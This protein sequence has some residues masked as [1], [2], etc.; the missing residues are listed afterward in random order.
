VAAPE[1]EDPRKALAR[2]GLAPK[3]SFSQNFLVARSVVEAIAEAAVPASGAH[4]VELG[5]GLGTLTGALL[6]R[7]ARVTAVERDR[8][9]IA[10]LKS[11]L[12]DQP[13]VV[14]E[15]DAADI[16]LGALAVDGPF[17]LAGNLPYA[18][19]GAILTNLGR[20]RRALTQAVLMI[21]KEVRDRLLASPGTK[22]WGMSSVFVQAAFDVRPV[23]RVPAGAFHP[24]PK[25]ESAV[26]R[27]VPRAVA[28]AEET[29]SFVRVV[30]AGFGTR[31]KTL[32]NALG[33]EFERD[34]V[35]AALGACGIDGDR[36]AETLT[37]EELAALARAME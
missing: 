29:P 22:T 17:A 1:W 23:L 19:T 18:A 6:R 30:H 21:Q 2:H 24:A 33:R 28:R 4:V 32:R 13:L 15:A 12:A 10:V 5:P 25:V 7:G 35:A 11:D 14:V 27:L 3:R 34:R 36:R 20:H 8:D 16:D 9:M 37:I 31:R 26:I